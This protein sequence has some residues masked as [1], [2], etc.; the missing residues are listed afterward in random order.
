MSEVLTVMLVTVQVLYLSETRLVGGGFDCNPMLFEANKDGVWYT[1]ITLFSHFWCQ[2]LINCLL[3]GKFSPWC[4]W[5]WYL[6]PSHSILHWIHRVLKGPSRWTLF[7]V[8]LYSSL[9]QNSG[10]FWHWCTMHFNIMWLLGAG[11]SLHSWTK[12]NPLFWSPSQILW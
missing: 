5:T 8:L 10:W 7:C 9:N 1:F 4:W 2:L 6:Y 3:A 12:W 11:S